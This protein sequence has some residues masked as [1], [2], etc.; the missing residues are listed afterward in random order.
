MSSPFELFKWEAL[1]NDKSIFLQGFFT[2]IEVSVLA[3]ILALIL[4]LIFGILGSSHFKISKKISR[5]YVSF[6]Q[7]TPLVVQ[8]FFL[9][10][11]FPHIGIVL[12]IYAVGVLGIGIYHGAYIAEVVRG[13]I[14]AVPKGQM[15]AAVS[16]GFNYIQCMAYIIIPQ[17][18]KIILPPLTNQ[19]V[20]LI[21]NTSVLAMVAGGDLM[22]QADSWASNNLYYGPAYVVTGLMY[23]ALCLPLARYAKRLEGKAQVRI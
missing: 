4:G 7:N 16:Q 18:I 13:G 6:F 8:I 21:K 9:Y 11:G 3:L 20:S 12:P 1:F 5:I 22:Y 19:A 15:E 17:A 10:N 14:E 2:T 23:L